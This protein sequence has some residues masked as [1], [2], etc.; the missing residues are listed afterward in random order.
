MSSSS[1]STPSITSLTQT[2]MEIILYQ[3][4]KDNLSHAQQISSQRIPD[5]M[6]QD[7]L[8][9]EIQYSVM[10]IISSVNCLEAYINSV[11]EDHFHA[12]TEAERKYSKRLNILNKWY[13][14]PLILGSG[15]TFDTTVPPFSNFKQINS[16]RNKIVHWDAAVA[17]ATGSSL[18]TP[19]YEQ[20]NVNNANLAVTTIKN[21]ISEFCSLTS[22]PLPSWL[23]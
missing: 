6:N 4:A 8:K 19:A 14:T 18:P 12:N 20:N 9:Q 16:Y 5:P 3:S 1:S 2:F 22:K 21:L 13:L 11:L 10:T 17:S 23:V 15:R 7:L